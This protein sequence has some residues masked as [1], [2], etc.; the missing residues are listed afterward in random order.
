MF[1]SFFFFLTWFW[2]GGGEV[3]FKLPLRQADIAL[4]SDPQIPYD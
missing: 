2:G 1:L 4:I 3:L